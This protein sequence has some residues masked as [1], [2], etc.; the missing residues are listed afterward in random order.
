MAGMPLGPAAEPGIHLITLKRAISE[1]STSNLQPSVGD[2][3]V[4]IADETE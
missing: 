2:A 3:I 4:V 1:I